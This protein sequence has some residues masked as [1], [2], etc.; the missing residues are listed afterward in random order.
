MSQG[1]EPFPFVDR[2]LARR[3]ERAEAHGN[4]QAVEARAAVSPAVGAAWIEVA[5]A[6]AMFDGVDSPLTQ[7]FGLGLFDEV[8]AAELARIEAF[9]AER[10]APVFHEVSP[11]AQSSLLELLTGRGYQ[12]FEFTSVMFRPVVMTSA[13]APSPHRR[14]RVRLAGAADQGVWVG[15]AAAGWGEVPEV[16]G[17]MRDLGI[18][19]AARSDASCFLAELDGQPIAAGLLSIHGS[20]AVLGGASTVPAWRRHGAQQA[21]LD[22]RLRFAAGQRCETAMMC[23]APGSASQRNAERHGFRIAYTRL[24]W[25]RSMRDHDTA[26]H[27]TGGPPPALSVAEGC[28]P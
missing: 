9:F 4:A 19:T 1:R 7:T 21:L 15:T 5:G 8:T 23:A 24:K 27:R 22:A 17:F 10:G 11:L 28:P 6:Y 20:V 18:V 14:V 26:S 25:R 16:A 2:E 12:P 13:A 3:L